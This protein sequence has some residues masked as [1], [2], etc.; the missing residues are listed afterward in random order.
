MV[1]ATE[2][3]EAWTKAPY[4]ER[5]NSVEGVWGQFPEHVNLPMDGPVDE[6]IAI[7]P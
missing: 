1:Q 5:A 7:C 3:A 6:G 4:P 2:S